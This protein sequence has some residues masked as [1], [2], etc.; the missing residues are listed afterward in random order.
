MFGLMMAIA[1]ISGLGLAGGLFYVNG[2]LQVGRGLSA[3]HAG[4]LALFMAA[5]MLFSIPVARL[6]VLLTGKF[7]YLLVAAGVFQAVI[8]A[9]FTQLGL[10]TSYVLIGIGLFVL[11]VGI[12]Q[13][14]GLGLQL[15][16]NAVP[17]KDIGVA[18]T[19]LRFNQQLGTSFGF[20]MF[21]TVVIHYLAA[22][23]TGAAGAANVGGQLDLGVL[24]TLPPAQHL[25]AVSTFVNATHVVFLVSG[26]LA[27]IPSALALLIRERSY[28]TRV[29]EPALEPVAA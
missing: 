11:G 14:L 5:G 27:L 1:G 7:K 16:Q 25:A 29:T 20:A 17:L 24:A 6:I 22:H 13:T 8:L 2:Y 10:S 12:G 9:L 26:I 23:L 3:G 4:L 18:T 28:K 15:T 19:S 21:S